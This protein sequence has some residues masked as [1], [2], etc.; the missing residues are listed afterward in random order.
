MR[1][2][3]IAAAVVRLITGYL[4]IRTLLI[5]T[6]GSQRSPALAIF[7]N[8]L[9]ES[10]QEISSRVL[11]WSAELFPIAFS[12]TIARALQTGKRASFSANLPQWKNFAYAA[13]TPSE[14]ASQSAAPRTLPYR[15]WPRQSS[16][17]EPSLFTTF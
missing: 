15:A 16:R 11:H 12:H 17:P 9:R 13:A 2:I 6:V 7:L 5:F 4:A 3:S 1:R 8:F 10:S 14:V